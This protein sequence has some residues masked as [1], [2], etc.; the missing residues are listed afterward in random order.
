MAA[1]SRLRSVALK[2]DLETYDDFVELGLLDAGGPVAK[3]RP[4]VDV[5]SDQLYVVAFQIVIH[6]AG[7]G[8]DVIIG[9]LTGIKASHFVASWSFFG[10]RK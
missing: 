10:T 3:I 1:C 7:D 4:G 9:Q 8:V 2:H 6:T 5:V